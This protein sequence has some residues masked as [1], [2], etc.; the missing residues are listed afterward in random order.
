MFRSHVAVFPCHAVH[1]IG[2]AGPNLLILQPGAGTPA[3]FDGT[4]DDG[5]SAG[6]VP[7]FVS[8]HLTGTFQPLTHDQLAALLA[9]TKSAA[10]EGH[11][12][13][14]K[15][16]NRFDSTAQHPEWLGYPQQPA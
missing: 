12:E 16:T 13:L 9:R 4:L 3:S 11:Y 7:T 6:M 10:A 5:A 2:P 8:G 15:T 1:G 14:F